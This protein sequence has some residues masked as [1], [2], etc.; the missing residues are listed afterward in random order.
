MKQ[1]ICFFRANAKIGDCIISSFIPRELEKLVL[2][3]GRK[4][5]EISVV[6]SESIASLYYTN[7]HIDKLIILPP[8]QYAI[9][10]TPHATTPLLVNVALL[11][12]LIRFMLYTWIHPYNLMLTDVTI[13]TFRNNLYFRMLRVKKILHLSP[14]PQLQSH[15]T[16]VYQ[17][18]LLQLGAK[19]V[20]TSY[21]LFIPTSKKKQALSFLQQK[22]IGLQ[23]FIVFNPC[24]SISQRQLS[25]QQIQEILRLL[26]A[27]NI[28]VILLDYQRRYVNFNQNAIL[29]SLNDILEVA[30]IIEHAKGVI[31]VDTSILHITDIYQ[32]PMLA[33]YCND[34]YS[35]E[36]NRV[37]CASTNPRTLYLYSQ[38]K[39]SD[40][41]LSTLQASV[42][43][44]LK[45]LPN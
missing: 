28:P 17:N 31:T 43:N 29:C 42:S 3:K 12:G 16:K 2:E 30:T 7:P 41:S 45:N 19:N 34:K 33:L 9:P 5:K 44:F 13:H 40:I 38:D 6:V 15:F 39:I 35:I 20:D 32:K 11:L 21:E 10:E 4:E 22:N 27:H 14:V 24:G 37:V 26:R 18:L 25:E 1:R 8:M 23:S 36:N